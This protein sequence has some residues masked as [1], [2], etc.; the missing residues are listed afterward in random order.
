MHGPMAELVWQCFFQ[1]L[2]ALQVFSGL[3]ITD[4]SVRTRMHEGAV[5]VEFS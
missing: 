1:D 4:N 3:G 2:R 5:R